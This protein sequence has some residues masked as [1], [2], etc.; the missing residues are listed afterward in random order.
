MKINVVV[1]LAGL[2]L[3]ISCTQKSPIEQEAEVVD[4]KVINTENFSK[5][6]NPSK[7]LPYISDIKPEKKKIK[8]KNSMI[9]ISS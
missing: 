5:L 8:I 6:P 3:F 9:E 1:I 4:Q 7:E 2:I